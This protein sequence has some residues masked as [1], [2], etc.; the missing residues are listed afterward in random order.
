MK[1][2]IRKSSIKK[3]LKAATTGKA[4]RAIKKAIDPT[5][6]KKGMGMLKKPK[7]AIYNKVYRRTSFSLG[8]LLKRLIK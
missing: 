8:S 2:G 7:K 1:I 6:G 5:Y 3:S 4:K